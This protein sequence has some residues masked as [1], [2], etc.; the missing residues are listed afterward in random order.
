MPALSILRTSSLVAFCCE[1]HICHAPTSKPAHSPLI[2]ALSLT[3]S[4]SVAEHR[5]LHAL[6]K[7]LTHPQS[8][9][10]G[11]GLALRPRWQ[12]PN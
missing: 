3:T 2:L 9:S 1:Q 11:A 5:D 6:L 12:S 8:H 7:C 10:P 4:H